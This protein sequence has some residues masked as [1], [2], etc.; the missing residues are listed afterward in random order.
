MSAY[1]LVRR[2]ESSTGGGSSSSGADSV[3]GSSS[4]KRSFIN[5][6]KDVFEMLASAGPYLYRDTLLLQKVYT[7]AFLCW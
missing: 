7:L 6:P 2:T 5:L 4:L 1:E 3:T